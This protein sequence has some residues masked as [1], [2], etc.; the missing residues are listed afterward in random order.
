MCKQQGNRKDRSNGSTRVSLVQVLNSEIT[1]SMGDEVLIMLVL[2]T[3]CNQNSLCCGFIYILP[4]TIPILF[5][6]LTGSCFL[7][8]NALR[9]FTGF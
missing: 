5:K 7:L 3:K 9:L 2:G 1:G 6:V 4:T 8:A